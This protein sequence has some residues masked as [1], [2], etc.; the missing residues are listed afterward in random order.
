MNKEQLKFTDDNAYPPIAIT[1]CNPSYAREMLD[2]LGGANSEMSAISLYFYN[3]LITEQNYQDISYIF[4]KISI[5]EMHHMEIF[6]KLAYYL[7]EDPRMWTWRYNRRTYW[8]PSYNRYPVELSRLIHNALDGECAAIEKY[9]R[10]IRCI[11]NENIVE[12]LSRIVQDEKVHVRI[13]EQ[14]I[15]EYHL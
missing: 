10:Q 3:N 7:G 1:H 6:G 9:Q 13:F 11:D 4:H 5:V 8:T 15:K 2:N 14:L 12:N